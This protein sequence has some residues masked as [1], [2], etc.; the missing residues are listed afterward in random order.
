MRGTCHAV[1]RASVVQAV[2]VDNEG[3]CASH[4]NA[5]RAEAAR[6][7]VIVRRCCGI[8]DSAGFRF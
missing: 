1:D 8:V 6:H 7:L 3:M 5:K 2:F 4:E